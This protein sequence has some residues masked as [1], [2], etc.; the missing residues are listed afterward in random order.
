MVN[1]PPLSNRLIKIA[2]ARGRPHAGLCRTRASA[3]KPSTMTNKLP[4]GFILLCPRKQASG[5]SPKQT[6]RCLRETAR[7]FLSARPRSTGRP[8]LFRKRAAAVFGRRK[9]LVA[10]HHGELLVV[11]PGLLGLGWLLDL[12]QIEVVHHPAVFEHLATLGE[13]VV[14]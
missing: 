14:D 13:H 8:W 12:E 1:A 5:P 7:R 9:R 2:S 11:I 10:L 4:S 3:H 6:P